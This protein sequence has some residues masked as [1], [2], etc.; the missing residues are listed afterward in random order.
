MAKRWMFAAVVVM[1]AASVLSS[2]A[3]GQEGEPAGDEMSFWD[4][5]KLATLSTKIQALY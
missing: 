2:A 1:L 4:V 3:Y 5:I